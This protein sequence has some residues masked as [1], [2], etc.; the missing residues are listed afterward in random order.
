MT[1][2]VVLEAWAILAVLMAALWAIHLAIR[3]AAIVDAGW[4]IGLPIAAAWYAWRLSGGAASWLLTLLV[5]GWGLRL[6]GY[7]LLTRVIGQAEEGRYAELRR[8][9]RTALPAKFFLFFQAQA[10]LDV[11]LSAPFLLVARTSQSIGVVHAAATALW[12]VAWTGESIA[13]RQLARFKQDPRHRGQVCDVGLWR[14][15]R[16]PNYFFEWLIWVAYALY[17]SASPWGWLAWISPALILY[18]LFRVTGIPETEAQAVRSRGDA[19]RRYQA[20]TSAF[21]PWF[22]R[23]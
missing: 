2:D 16:H 14:Y 1:F 6:G 12:V 9:W 19:Y 3:N 4:A 15:S 10:L 18:F 7:L 13:D 11:V 23:S 20:T 5:A 8:R 17:A 21:V 22:P